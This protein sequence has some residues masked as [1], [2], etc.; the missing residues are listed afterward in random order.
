M[1]DPNPGKKKKKKKQDRKGGAK[2]REKKRN[3][4]EDDVAKFLRLTPPA[5][6]PL[7]KSMYMNTR[8][9]QV[10]HRLHYLTV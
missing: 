10:R 7:K 3:V 6:V 5:I 9:N 8:A 1:M 4:M 2:E